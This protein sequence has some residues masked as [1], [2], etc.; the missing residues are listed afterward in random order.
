MN[1]WGKRI[2]TGIEKGQEGEGGGERGDT[3]GG[4]QGGEREATG[5]GYMDEQWVNGYST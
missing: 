3:G 2:T 4:K 1:L 5:G